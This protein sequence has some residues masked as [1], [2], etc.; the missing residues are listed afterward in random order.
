[1]SLVESMGLVSALFDNTHSCPARDVHLMSTEQCLAALS[2]S[3]G[4]V[5]MLSRW[6]VSV[7]CLLAVYGTGAVHAQP[8]SVKLPMFAHPFPFRPFDGVEGCLNKAP[9]GIK[10]PRLTVLHSVLYRRVIL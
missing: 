4:E 9:E 3:L 1:M 2:A 10:A 7:G 8:T 5:L 6:A